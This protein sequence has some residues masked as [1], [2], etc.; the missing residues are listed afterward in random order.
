ML[1][2]HMYYGT[3]QMRVEDLIFN[4]QPRPHTCK[5][6]KPCPN[7]KRNLW[8]WFKTNSMIHKTI[9]LWNFFKMF[10]M[11]SHQVPIMKCSHQDPNVFPHTKKVGK[12]T[13]KSGLMSQQFTQKHQTIWGG[14]KIAQIM[15]TYNSWKHNIS[16]ATHAWYLVRPIISVHKKWIFLVFKSMFFNWKKFTFKKPK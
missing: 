7:K 10:P 8:H 11:C 15:G 13:R 2:W 3:Y 14:W 5:Q 4:W 1:N 9:D 12:F 16:S 6:Q